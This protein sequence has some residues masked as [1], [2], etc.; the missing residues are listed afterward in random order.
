MSLHDTPI[1]GLSIVE[2]HASENGDPILTTHEVQ[3][4]DNRVLRRLAAEANTECVQGR[5]STM[6][7]L[8][9]YFHGQKTLD[10]YAE[11]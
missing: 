3:S 11:E 2:E 7:E 10:D 8:Q 1:S 6:L 9:A 4:Y 5:G